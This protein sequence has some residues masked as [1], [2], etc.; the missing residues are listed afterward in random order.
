MIK[1]LLSR[2]MKDWIWRRS[3]GYLNL[4][5]TLCSG[6]EIDL[7]SFADWCVY[8]D[9]FVEGEYDSAINDSLKSRT[10][11]NFRVVDLGANVGFF[12]L[13]VLDRLRRQGGAETLK[14]RI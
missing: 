13:R 4:R 5:R 6:I 9:I 8:N 1:H 14:T 10:S 3:S 7:Q 12:T 2:G 11:Q